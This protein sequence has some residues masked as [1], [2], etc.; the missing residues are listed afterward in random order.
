M[1]H[2]IHT[3][4]K[5]INQNQVKASFTHNAI[6]KSRKIY[7]SLSAEILNLNLNRGV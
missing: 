2:A 7:C 4:G 3:I 6:Y 5:E 1:Y